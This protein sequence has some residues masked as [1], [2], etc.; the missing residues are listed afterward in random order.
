MK[1][2]ETELLIRRAWVRNNFRAYTLAAV[3]AG[4]FSVGAWS[5]T[6]LA[7]VS[8][9]ITDPSGAVVPGPALRL[10]AKAPG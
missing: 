10:L 3:L 1:K 7:A 8:G 5:Q 4:L 9:T 2:N 6:Q